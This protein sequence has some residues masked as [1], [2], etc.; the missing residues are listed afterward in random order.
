MILC[1]ITCY[2]KLRNFLKKFKG[3]LRSGPAPRPHRESGD[4]AISSL[5]PGRRGRL[6]ELRVGRPGSAGSDRPDPCPGLAL[7]RGP[8]PRGLRLGFRLPV[9]PNTTTSFLSAM[10][11]GAGNSVRR[12]LRAVRGAQSVKGSGCLPGT[13]PR[14]PGRTT[15]AVQPGEVGTPRPPPPRARPSRVLPA[16]AARVPQVGCTS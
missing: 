15:G 3:N 11:P 14:A 1:A 10:R 4:P 16:P 6:L 9:A 13:T 8:A 12:G 2:S 7:V 5:P